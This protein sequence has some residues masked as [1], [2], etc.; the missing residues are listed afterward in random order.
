MRDRKVT[1]KNDVY[2]VKDESY[3]DEY[4]SYKSNYVVYK[5]DVRISP[6]YLLLDSWVAEDYLPRRLKKCPCC[7]NVTRQPIEWDKE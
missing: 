1:N 3:E 5:N 2:V 6:E 4:G 7:D